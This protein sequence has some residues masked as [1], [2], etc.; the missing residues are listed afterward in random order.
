MQEDEILF[1]E[2][3]NQKLKERGLTLKHLSDHTGIALK[4]LESFS[5]GRF[6]RLPSAPYLHGYFMKLG[7]IMGFDPDEW[8]D[9]IKAEDTVHKAGAGDRMPGNRFS[10]M[11]GRALLWSGVAIA[12][13]GIYFTA[14]F[15]TIIGEPTIVIASPE[16]QAV[17]FST[18]VSQ[19]TLTITGFVHNG[20]TLALNGGAIPLDRE[21]FFST[22]IV[23]QPGSNT[24]KLEARKIL[25]RTTVLTRQVYYNNSPIIAPAP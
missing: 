22:E 4:H 12:L 6:E 3:F 7:P 9:R 24:I 8:W 16:A 2:F 18:N 5:H 11:R 15:T 25:G 13:I 19:S 1:T 14:R 20:D 10:R 21:G 17:S 23:L